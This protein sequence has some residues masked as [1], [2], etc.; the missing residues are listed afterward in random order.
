MPDFRDFVEV[1]RK[2]NDLV[3]VVGEDIRLEDHGSVLKGLSPFHPETTPS[4]VVWPESQ[5]FRDYAKGS[6][7]GGDVFAY[8]QERDGIGF[9]EALMMLAARAGVQPPN[10]DAETWEADL[11]AIKER[12]EVEHTLSLAATYYHQRLPSKI[13]ADY[14]RG[15]YGFTDAIID[16]LQLGWADGHLYEYLTKELGR[17]SEAVLKT[18]LVVLSGR[19]RIPRDLF[20]ERLVFPYW[21]GGRV[22]YFIARATEYTADK[23]WE[24]AKYK[25]QLVH[26]DKHPYVSREVSNAYFYNEDAARGAKELLITEGVTDCISAMQAGVSCISPVTV[27]F[28]NKDVPRLLELTARAE[29]V[30]VCNDSEVSGAGAAGALRTV[31]ALW[32]GKREA[33]MATI[34][35]PAGTDKIDINTLVATQGPESLRAVIAGAKSY[36]EYLL[37]Q[38]PE[39]ASNGALSA[40]LDEVFAALVGCSTLR[41]DMMMN[42]IRKRHGVG[43]RVQRQRLRELTAEF[44]RE[45]G[46]SEPE[47]ALGAPDELAVNLGAHRGADEILFDVN[48]VVE[49]F[50]SDRVA[51]GAKVPFED[52]QAPW[53]RQGNALVRLKRPTEGVVSLDLVTNRRAE[54]TLLAEVKWYRETTK[55]GMSVRRFVPPPR[56]YATAVVECPPPGLPEIRTL[57]TTPSFGADGKLLLGPGLHRDDGVWHEPDPELVVPGVPEQPSTHDIRSALALLTEDLLVDF[58]FVSDSDRAHALAA[59]LLPFVRQMLHGKTPLHLV[60]A[61][62]V[63]SG[64]GLLCELVSII[65]TGEEC[66][67]RI[68]PES[69]EEVRKALTTELVSGKP[70]VLLDNVAEMKTLASGALAGLLTS[71]VWSDRRLGTNEQ[72]YAKNTAMWMLTGNNVRLS[73]D[74]ARRAV[75]IRISTNRADPSK[76]SGFKH[77]PI[78]EW[79]KR[80]RGDLVH[81][82]LVLGQAWVTEGQPRMDCT[83]KRMGSFE[84]WATC[85]GGILEVAGVKGFLDNVDELRARA[86]LDAG[87]WHEFIAVWWRH[88][89]RTMVAAA[90]LTELCERHELML[91][92]RQNGNLRSQQ[93]R[94]G[95][96]LHAARD[97]VFGRYQL[98]VHSRDRERKARFSLQ[99]LDDSDASDAEEGVDMGS[100]AGMTLPGKSKHIDPWN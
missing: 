57:I 96:C 48:A 87:D 38:V 12:R 23:K 39:G 67:V 83:G 15:H 78:M 66:P 4:F 13:R 68:L 1:V 31:R 53:F 58:P 75:R 100:D 86:D 61:P 34:P 29:K 95:I 16:E 33:C 97:R 14:Y 30:V 19:A 40:A 51:S 18:G 71:R 8:V 62:A 90:D 80:R 20:E 74:L 45:E 26:S 52:N 7:L 70:I 50:N 35:L 64:K 42:R 76:R 22:V 10:R 5:R 54:V 59:I 89:G 98:L 44:L 46:E 63:G 21:R 72:I 77:D 84:S 28:R 94:M 56:A 3:A 24:S 92:V 47:V 41:I 85:M 88:Y 27:A 9:K 25:K 65:V 81:A 82:V 79:A 69:E 37:S 32:E 60:E 43:L 17:S 36:P 93:V 11:L 49:E 2:R 99:P 6:S 91:R 55:K 73:P